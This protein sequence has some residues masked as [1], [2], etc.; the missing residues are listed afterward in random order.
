MGDWQK[1]NTNF[2]YTTEQFLVPA[3]CCEDREE[4]TDYVLTNGKPILGCVFAMCEEG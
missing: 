4:V 3:S 2:P 1:N